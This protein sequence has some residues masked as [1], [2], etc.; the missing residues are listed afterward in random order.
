MTRP[1][2]PFARHKRYSG[3]SK[4]DGLMAAVLVLEHDAAN[5]VM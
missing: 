4:Y 2:R 1:D 5:G 3:I